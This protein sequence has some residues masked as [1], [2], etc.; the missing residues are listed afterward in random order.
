MKLWRS[1]TNH[2]TGGFSPLQLVFGRN[3]RTPAELLSDDALD[4]LGLREIREPSPDD[5]AAAAQYRKTQR[6]RD[7]ARKL[8][9][10][11]M[12]TEKLKLAQRTRKLHVDKA[13]GRGQWV[14]AWREARRV[15]AG[16]MGRAKGAGGQD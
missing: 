2:L 16:R 11:Q 13:F 3:P 12:A 1:R 5:D 7:V 9:A 10:E 8:L 14:Y 4:E 15:G 6:V